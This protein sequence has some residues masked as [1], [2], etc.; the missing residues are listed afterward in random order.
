MHKIAN[1]K[2]THTSSGKIY[3][4]GAEKLIKVATPLNHKNRGL[5]YKHDISTL[6]YQ[7]CTQEKLRTSKFQGIPAAIFV[8]QFGS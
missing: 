6:N 2:L 7:S 1:F 3:Y 4:E 5:L 8:V